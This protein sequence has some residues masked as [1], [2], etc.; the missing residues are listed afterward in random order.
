MCCV[1]IVQK[2]CA[3]VNTHATKLRLMKQQYEYEGQAAI[4][5]QQEAEQRKMLAEMGIAL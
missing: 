1:N 4:Q 3:E 2:L 5:E